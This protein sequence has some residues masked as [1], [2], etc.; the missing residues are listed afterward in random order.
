VFFFF[1]SSSS[2][3]KVGR[4]DRDEEA[5]ERTTGAGSTSKVGVGSWNWVE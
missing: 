5:V 1:Y 3:L 4:L 2:L